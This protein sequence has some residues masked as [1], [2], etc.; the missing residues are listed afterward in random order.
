MTIQFNKNDLCIC[1]H[2]FVHHSHLLKDLYEYNFCTDCPAGTKWVHEFKLN[3]L[4]FLQKKFEAI[5]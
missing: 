4:D 2:K 3:N 1:G 5:Q